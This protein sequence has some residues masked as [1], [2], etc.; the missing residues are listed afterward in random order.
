MTEPDAFDLVSL[1]ELKPGDYIILD[2]GSEIMVRGTDTEGC[3]K[4]RC[5]LLLKGRPPIVVEGYWRK[6]VRR[7][8]R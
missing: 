7:L 4:S 2:D 8:H 3:T 5:R 6:I 1:N